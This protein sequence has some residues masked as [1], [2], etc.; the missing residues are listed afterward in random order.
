MLPAVTPGMLLNAPQCT[1]QPLTQR[2]TWSKMSL[3]PRV[4]MLFLPGCRRH[5][6]PRPCEQVVVTFLPSPFSVLYLCS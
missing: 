1:G 3:V 2:I 6:K 4:R 5:F